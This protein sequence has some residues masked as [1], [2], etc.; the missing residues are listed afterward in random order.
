MMR[1][2]S[3][4]EMFGGNPCDGEGYGEQECNTNPCPGNIIGSII[5]KY[6]EIQ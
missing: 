1:V 3:Q 4:V 2:R 6:E 5:T